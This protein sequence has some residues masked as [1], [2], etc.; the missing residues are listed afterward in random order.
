M[1]SRGSSGED[2]HKTRQ[3][4]NQEQPKD[5]RE[6]N[7]NVRKSQGDDAAEPNVHDRVGDR[8]AFDRDR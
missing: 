6:A 7:E 4:E 1:N 2:N 3:V 5:L 8:P